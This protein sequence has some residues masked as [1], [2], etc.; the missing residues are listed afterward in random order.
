MDQLVSWLTIHDPKL[1]TGA[2]GI[3][4]P[5]VRDRF[6]LM[7]TATGST[8]APSNAQITGQ[9]AQDA[10]NS[11]QVAADA[12]KQAG[13]NTLDPAFLKQWAQDPVGGAL[14]LSEMARIS[15]GYQPQTLDNSGA[16]SAQYQQ[17]LKNIGSNPIFVLQMSDR[18]HYE[19]T[20]SDWNT[21]IDAIANTFEGITA[22]DKNKIVTGLKDL[23]TAASSKMET[24][25]T[26]SIFVQN[27][28]NVDGKVT[29]YLYNSS[30][31]FYEKSGKGFD[32][33][34]NTF[35]IVR[36]ELAFQTQLWPQ[37][38]AKV[39]AKFY[40]SIDDWLNNNSTSVVGQTPVVKAFH[41]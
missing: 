13:G 30:V 31:S 24:T 36:L 41:A 8:L 34:Q 29:L 3:H 32:V 9:K 19:R 25:Q 7:A 2:Q 15:A 6:R 26:Q 5:E 12:L 40:S 18:Q 10:L 37:I 14:T 38:V 11:D 22:E 16:Q 21:V 23:A 17:Y 20:S 27:A 4:T 35:D 39:A 33:K 28:V 1:Y